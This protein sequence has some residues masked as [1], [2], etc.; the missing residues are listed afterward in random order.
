MTAETIALCRKMIEGSDAILIGAGAGLSTAAGL[1]YGGKR[2]ADNFPEFIQQ[3]GLTDMYSSAFFPFP[4]KEERWAYFS[5][6]IK[7]NRYD[8]ETPALYKDLLTLLKDK[9]YFVITTNAD[10]LFFKAGFKEQRVFATQGDYSKFQ[11]SKACHDTLYDNEESVTQMVERQSQC[12]IPSVLLPTCPVC[13]ED[14]DAH[15]RKDEFFIENDDWKSNARRYQ[16]FVQSNSE[17]RLVMLEF[18]VGFN[19]PS[20]IRWPFEQLA[21]GLPQATLIRINKDDVRSRYDLPEGNILIKEDLEPF[22]TA[23]DQV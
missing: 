18:G 5:R 4:S 6:H 16:D 3:Y 13:G 11:C 22:I 10:G 19:T 8:F 20:I 14:L 9:N 15:L 12:R 2:F 21:A 1:E 17:S 23:L 7:V